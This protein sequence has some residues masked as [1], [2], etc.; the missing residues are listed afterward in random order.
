M[1]SELKALRRRRAE[2]LRADAD[3]ARRLA[4]LKTR[5]ECIYGST[6][7]AA[8]LAAVIHAWR[9]HSAPSGSLWI[10]L[11]SGRDHLLG[12]PAAPLVVVEYGDYQC[13]ECAEAHRLPARTAHWLAAGRLCIAFRHFPL[14][15]A[16]PLAMR[17]A[18]AA[19]AAATQGRF[20]EMHDRLMGLVS[21][22]DGR[23]HATM[24]DA[25]IE[26]EHVARKA[27]L[28]VERF[29]AD[30]DDPA[31]LRRI[32]EDLWS[33]VASGVNGTPAFYVNDERADVGGVE[34]LYAQ[35]ARSSEVPVDQGCRPASP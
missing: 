16:H 1:C 18:Q 14:I 25:G 24:T 15:D 5:L 2:A 29:R 10:E 23:L 22:R 4:A 33:G 3:L 9:R 13:F 31:V 28:D 27:G 6:P 32:L 8:D 20:W 35:M 34:E 21:D 12:D 11:Q 19:E 17:R 30:I 26:L 7:S